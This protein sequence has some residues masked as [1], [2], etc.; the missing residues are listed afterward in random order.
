MITIDLRTF[1]QEYWA[2]I[3]GKPKTPELLRKF[4]TDEELIGHI[5][6][7]ENPFPSYELI[8]EE[9]ICEGDKV[10]VVGRV[11]GIHKG[12]LMGIPP[13]GKTIDLPFS[14][15]YQVKDEKIVKSWL[16]LNQM[17][18]MKQLGVASSN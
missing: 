16:F 1:I 18:L 17:E 6:A 4:M 5:M 7:F 9:F 3:S 15:I 14:V 13:T 10:S 8:A 11:R 12:D 2:S